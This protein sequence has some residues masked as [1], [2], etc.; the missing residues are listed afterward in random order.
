MSTLPIEFTEQHINIQFSQQCQLPIPQEDG[1]GRACLSTWLVASRQLTPEE[2]AQIAGV[3]VETVLARCKVYQESRSSL[4][5][6]DRRHFNPGQQ[7]AY[8]M[9]AQQVNAVTQWVMNLLAGESNS[10]RH[11]CS[12]LDEAVDDRTVDRFLNRSG[13]R[14][15]EDAGL[16]QKVEAYQRQQ[17]EAAYWTGVRREPF[18]GVCDMA[19]EEGWD[20]APEAEATAALT[21][22][23]LVHNGAYAALER[24]DIPDEGKTS[25]RRFW[26]GML[27]FLAGSGGERLSHAKRFDWESV[28]GLLSGRNG[29]SASFLRDRL[30]QFLT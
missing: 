20:V 27:T 23:H 19:L 11:L 6:V 29:L 28:R 5:L 14:Q 16:R 15:A 2:G 30:H 7:T 26:H 25:N 17:L 1:V 3:S 4:G 10:G 13:M 9:E 24:L 18:V 12:Q 22:S 21:T 8:R